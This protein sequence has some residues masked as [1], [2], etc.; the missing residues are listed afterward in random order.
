MFPYGFKKL[1]I[2]YANLNLDFTKEHGHENAC[3]F[4]IS[5]LVAKGKK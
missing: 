3:V 1:I 4:F 2:I 5:M